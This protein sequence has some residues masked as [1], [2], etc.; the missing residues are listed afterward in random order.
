MVQLQVLLK[1]ELCKLIDEIE[2]EKR[3]IYT[4]SIGLITPNDIKMN[5]AIRT[6]T[7]NKNTGDGVMGLGSGIVWDS[8]SKN[9]YE[10]VLLKSKF[11]TEPL[12]YF[13]IFETMK[14]ENGEIKFLDEHLAQNEICSRLFSI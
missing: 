2:K 1:S 5:V 3:G 7:I 6:I 14:Y 9:E 10:E 13:E 11:L 4:G 12:D 8:D